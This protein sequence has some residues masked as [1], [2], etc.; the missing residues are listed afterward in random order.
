MQ[1][2]A[3]AVYR[4][5][6]TALNY[7]IRKEKGLKINDLSFHLQKLGKKRENEMQSK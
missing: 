5:K 1:N 7:Y 6:S 2:A 3:K 4:G